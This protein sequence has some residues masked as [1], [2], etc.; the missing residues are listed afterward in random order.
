ME[1]NTWNRFS[2]EA[3]E[4]HMM[5]QIFQRNLKL[6]KGIEGFCTKPN[7]FNNFL[8]CLSVATIETFFTLHFHG[9]DVCY[10]MNANIEYVSIYM[11]NYVHVE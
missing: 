9:S 4:I 8:F 10:S 1:Y 6:T 7:S 5:N 2:D 3:I 11:Y